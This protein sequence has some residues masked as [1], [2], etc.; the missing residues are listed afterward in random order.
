[1]S[2]QLEELAAKIQRLEDI[3]AIKWLITRYAQGADEGNNI[4]IMLPL[5]TEDVVWEAKGLGRYEGKAAVREM[6]LGSP[7]FI[8]GTI[9]YMV[10]PAIEIAKDG[11][12]AQAFW[13]LW[14]TAE[15]PK[16]LPKGLPKGQSEEWEAVWIGGTY[17][18]ELIKVEGQWKFKQV[19]L[20]LKMASP[21]G[22]GWAKTPLRPFSQD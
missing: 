19:A 5:F 6:L 16:G 21:Y 9:H 10:S 14:E 1:M 13:Y 17:E 22:D 3:E 12:K 7:A 4:D 18:T 8:R 15:M 11:R 20:K 2:S